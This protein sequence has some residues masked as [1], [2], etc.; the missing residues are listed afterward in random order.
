MIVAA[1]APDSTFLFAD[2][3]GFTALTEAHGDH[4]A[5]ELTTE[6]FAAVRRLLSEHGAEEIK[7]LGDAVMLRVARA[8]DAVR[9]GIRIVRDVG[10]RHGMPS[11]RVGMHSGP[12]ALRGGDWFGT[13]V[14]IAAR[15]SA[16]AAGGEVLLTDGTRRAVG[17][18]AD[19]ELRARGEH[20]L[21]NVEA[22]VILYDVALGNDHAGAALPVDPVCRMAVS[23][24]HA[25]AQMIHNGRTHYFCSLRCANRFSAAP[26]RFTRRR[27]AARQAKGAAVAQGGSYLGRGLW[28]LLASRSGDR[29][30]E[31]E[32]AWRV[33]VGSALLAGAVRQRDYHE[34]RR[35]G[36][37]AALGLVLGRVAVGRHRGPAEWIA[38]AADAGIAAVWLWP[39]TTSID[40]ASGDTLG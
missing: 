31:M 27:D 1:A 22:P 7:T 6:F 16:L 5:A 11:I 8:D 39:S 33:A 17:D 35:L 25:A 37:S 26:Q 14:N 3:A 18:V 28:S 21:K 4:E 36:V 32:G 29:A 20:V 13:T 23:P 2:L 40:T 9:L 19:V 34:M 24:P 30:D 12:A 10:A 38:L 15:V